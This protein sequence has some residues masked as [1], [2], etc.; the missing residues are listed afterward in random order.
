MRILLVEDE[1]KIADFLEMSLAAE[2]FAVDVAYDG[3]VGMDMATRNEYDI[4][5]LDNMLPGKT[6]L[7]ICRQVRLSGKTCPILIL[8]VLDE[9]SKKVDLLDAGADDYLIKPFSLQELLARV[10]ALL[11]R[12]KQLKTTILNAGDLILDTKQHAVKRGKK[13]ITLTRKEFAL[14][15]YLM[16]NENVALSRGMLMEHVWNMAMDPFSNTIE[17]HILSLRKKIDVGDRRKLIHTV[18]G[19]GYKF[20]L[21]P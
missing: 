2:Y 11:R 20:G 6:G 4:M 14:L 17:S 3:E 13:E 16:K 10:R 8:S 7:E 19:V 5:I 9:T 21:T 1:Q 15:E 12:P 18:P